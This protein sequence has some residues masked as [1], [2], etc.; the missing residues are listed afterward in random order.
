MIPMPAAMRIRASEIPGEGSA[1]LS[2]AV[3]VSGR[4]GGADVVDAEDFGD[5]SVSGVVEG[6]GEG[7]GEGVTLGSGV[8]LGDGGV[9]AQ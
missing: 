3:D 6:V 7:S 9:D 5:G 2:A 1:A 8:K 4:A